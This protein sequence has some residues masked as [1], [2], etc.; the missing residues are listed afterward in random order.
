MFSSNTTSVT[1]GA[2]TSNPSRA[3]AF[4]RS[5][6]LLLLPLCYI[7]EN[8][9]WNRNCFPF[10]N[11]SGCFKDYCSLVFCVVFV[12]HCMSFFLWSLYCLSF[13]SCLQITPLVSSNFSLNEWR[14]Y[15][16]GRNLSYLQR[17][18]FL[19]KI[20]YFCVTGLSTVNGVSISST[21]NWKKS[22]SNCKALNSKD[23]NVTDM[24]KLNKDTTE[25]GMWTNIFRVEIS[26]HVDH[27]NTFCDNDNSKQ[28]Y[29]LSRYANK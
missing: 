5:F 28:I 7:K 9:I 25:T 19:N 6:Y 3:H 23:N 16:E 11:T 24:C 13:D 21:T 26:A 17:N 12:S 15:L 22:Q 20:F 14:Y 1:D 27:G 18:V 8:K 4:T 29:L 10:Q 2:G